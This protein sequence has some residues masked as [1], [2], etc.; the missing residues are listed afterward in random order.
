MEDGTGEDGTGLGAFGPT[1]S[2]GTVGGPA[3]ND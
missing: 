3:K 2:L 1:G